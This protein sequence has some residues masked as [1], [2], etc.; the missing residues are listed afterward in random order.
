MARDAIPASILLYP[1]YYA[2]F[3]RRNKM[4]GEGHALGGC[5]MCVCLSVSVCEEVMGHDKERNQPGICMRRSEK[6]RTRVESRHV[7]NGVRCLKGR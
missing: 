2:A 3:L 1:A 5:C 4:S 7:S 6:R